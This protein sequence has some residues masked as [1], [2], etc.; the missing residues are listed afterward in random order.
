MIEEPDRRML[1]QIARAAIVAKVTQGRPPA[2]PATAVSARPAGAFVSLHRHGSLRGCIG[3]L[4]ADLP[5]GEVI[6]DCA[7]AACSEDPRFPPVTPSELADLEIELSVLGPFESWT[8]LDD[9][10]VGR[11]GLFVEEGRARG[12]LLPQVARAREWLP[13]QFVEETCR[14][15]GLPRDAWQRGARLWRFTAEVFGD[16][17]AAEAR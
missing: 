11:D 4:E 7:R 1:V 14:K 10:E 12:L 5:L 3:R 13:R 8:S 6:V 2:V 15:A 16:Q 9:I 17:Q